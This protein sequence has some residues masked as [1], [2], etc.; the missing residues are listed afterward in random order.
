M[1][2]RNTFKEVKILN[3]S[4]L[5]PLPVVLGKKY[6]IDL[7]NLSVEF[8]IYAFENRFIESPDSS[9]TFYSQNGTHTDGKAPYYIISLD[10]VIFNLLIHKNLD[11]KKS[12]S[13]EQLLNKKI[14]AVLR[15]EENSKEELLKCYE[16]QL[17]C[18]T[19]QK[20]GIQTDELKM[21]ID[22]L[23]DQKT[24]QSK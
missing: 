8:I 21:F 2:P 17:K 5:Y 14:V 16:K 3:K 9:L 24:L 12:S 1:E 19:C 10:K 7:E 15:R 20:L 4:F 18:S 22:L 6:L 23:C 11:P 13:I